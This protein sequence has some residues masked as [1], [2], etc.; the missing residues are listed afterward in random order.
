MSKLRP[1]QQNLILGIAHLFH[2]GDRRVIMQCPTGSGKTL[3]ASEIASLVRKAEPWRDILYVVPRTEILEQTSSKLE[4]AN[5]RH[6]VLEAGVKWN[7]KNARGVCLAMSHTLARRAQSGLGNWRPGLIIL[8]ELHVLV[9]QH[10]RLLDMFPDA[11]VLSMTA[12]PTR[13]DGKP[14]D[15]F[16][17]LLQ[18]PQVREMQ[19]AGFLTPCIC[20]RA[21]SAR[22]SFRVR[23]GEYDQRQVAAEFE[24]IM[25][26][27]PQTWRQHA[28][29]RR[30]LTFCATIEQS[31]TLTRMYRQAGIRALHL[32]GTTDPEV[33]EQGLQAL[34]D[35]KID[36]I[37]NVGLFVEGLDLVETSCVTLAT[38]TN[39]LARYQQMV[40]RGLRPSP[41]S[42]KQNLLVIDHGGNIAQHGEPDHPLDWSRLAGVPN[43]ALSWEKLAEQKREEQRRLSALKLQHLGRLRHSMLY[44]PTEAPRRPQN[45]R[46]ADPAYEAALRGKSRA[47][48]PREC[49][50]WASEFAA[51]WNE[52]E[53]QR[54][55]EG[56]PLPR[57]NEPQTGYSEAR[58]LLLQAQKRAEQN[59]AQNEQTSAGQP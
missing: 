46:F 58:I 51:E 10:Y 36:V 4:A 7:E 47:V 34:R 18:G 12:T 25:P 5:C 53:E 55:R 15:V 43:A 39:S 50:E 16:G 57:E 3:I 22:V 30:T 33:R 40:G 19:K 38:S 35:H 31:Q 56:L 8:D 9:E 13:L 48:G 45:E 24:R 49:P 20:L 29:G 37:C 28:Q 2:Q 6:W 44:G 1:Y 42:N 59:A 26:A 41:H 32:D 52:L 21:Q 54:H 23:A 14:L 27:V 11:Y 17:S